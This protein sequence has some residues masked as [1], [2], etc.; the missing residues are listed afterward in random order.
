MKKAACVR[1]EFGNGFLRFPVTSQKKMARTRTF[2]FVQPRTADE[3]ARFGFRI[4]SAV[5]VQIFGKGKPSL[6]RHGRTTTLPM[7]RIFAACRRS[8]LNGH[9]LALCVFT[10]SQPTS[11]QPTSSQPTSS[12]PT[13]SQPNCWAI[14]QVDPGG[15]RLRLSCN[16]PFGRNNSVGPGRVPA[17]LPAGAV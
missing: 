2:S 17:R 7:A 9:S 13:S 15:P 3:P 11:S 10:S 8:H 1:S 16:N 14:L 4:S 6:G 12:Q 5:Q